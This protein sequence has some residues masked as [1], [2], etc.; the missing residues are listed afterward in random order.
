[1]KSH[2]RPLVVS[3][4]V[5]PWRGIGGGGGEDGIR[6]HEKLLTSTPLAGERLRPLGHLSVTARIDRN[7]GAHKVFSPRSRQMSR[8]TG[9]PGSRGREHPNGCNGRDGNPTAIRR[10]AW[11][12]WPRNGASPAS[13]AGPAGTETAIAGRFPPP[14]GASM[15]ADRPNGSP[16]SNK[17]PRFRPGL[18]E[19]VAFVQQRSDIRLR[20]HRKRP[21]G[22]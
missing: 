11:P 19:N 8:R 20:K 2:G 13:G 9:S 18:T 14:N 15:A 17:R 5:A 7:V 10:P 1:M 16:P 21:H 22:C 4:N 12:P 6:T 3:R